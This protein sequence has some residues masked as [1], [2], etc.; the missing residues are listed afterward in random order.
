MSE[1]SCE[2]GE[3]PALSDVAATATRWS[4]GIVANTV[5]RRRE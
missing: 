1:A 3:A 5:A 4:E 2:D